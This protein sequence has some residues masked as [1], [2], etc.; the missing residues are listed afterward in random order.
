MKAGLFSI[1]AI[2]W[3]QLATSRPQ[4][5][6]ITHPNIQVQ[7]L[8]DFA[9]HQHLHRARQAVVVT[10]VVTDLI[11]IDASEVIV[12]VDDH[13]NPVLT[14]TIFITQTELSTY[15][16]SSTYATASAVSEQASSQSY[17]PSS[18]PSAYVAPT[19]SSVASSAPALSSY[20]E[21]PVSQQYSPPQ[22]SSTPVTPPQSSS[23][24]SPPPAQSTSGSNSGSQGND[25][26]SGI[27]YSPYNADNSCKS[28]SQVANDLQQ[29]SNYEVIRLYG[30]DCNQISNVLAATKGKGVRLFLGI[31]DITQIQS[32]AQTIISAINGDWSPIYAVG[33]GNELVNDANE[34]AKSQVVGQV[35]SAIGQARGQL[36]SA[37]YSGPVVTVDTMVM[38]QQYPQLCTASDFCAINCHQFFNS[39]GTAQDAGDNILRWVENISAAAGGK[40]TI[41]TETGWPTQGQTN[42]LA[43]PSKENQDAAI[44]S[45]K[46]AFSG[47]Y[48]LFSSYNDLW[49]KNGPGTF[50]AEQ[51]W[52]IMGNAPS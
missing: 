52:G 7:T 50:G 16:P 2:S 35:T 29:V 21:S 46:S 23:S 45:I 39:T 9:G 26:N 12:Y 15:P 51:F 32:E 4:G 13:N 11:S 48:I 34:G 22:S 25:F 40:K 14:T 8:I 18:S 24:S 28:T 38:M 3:L 41:V 17:A 31:F 10:D 33:V 37:G 49:K 43:V 36:K 27:S 42:G 30:T 44:G 6:A 19:S 1:A 5:K 20:A 47:N